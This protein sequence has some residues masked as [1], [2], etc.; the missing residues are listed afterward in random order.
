MCS[1]ASYIVQL[2]LLLDKHGIPYLPPKALKNI[3]QEAI[4]NIDE[5]AVR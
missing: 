2:Q 1:Q 5:N 4:D 3:T